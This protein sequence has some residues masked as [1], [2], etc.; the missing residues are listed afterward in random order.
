MAAALSTIVLEW[1]YYMLLPSYDGLSENPISYI[2]TKNWL[3]FTHMFNLVLQANLA[4]IIPS[5]GSG[6]SFRK[7]VLWSNRPRVLDLIAPP[8]HPLCIEIFSKSVKGNLLQEW[9]QINWCSYQ[10]NIFVFCY[11]IKLIRDIYIFWIG[12][13]IFRHF[14]HIIKENWYYIW[15]V[16]WIWITTPLK[17]KWSFNI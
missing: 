1:S 3:V 14:R 4:Y 13:L 11:L 7:N 2:N 15:R 8:I 12:Q 6:L 9:N 10:Y 5:A 16:V 17:N